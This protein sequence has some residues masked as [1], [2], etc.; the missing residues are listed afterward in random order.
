M[1]IDRARIH[2]RGGNGGNGI[3]AFRREKFVPRGGPSGGDGGRGGSV[4]IESTEGLNTLL[5]FRYNP[6]H[7]AG[8]GRHGEGSKRH[9][10]D[11]EDIVIKVPVGTLVTDELT[12]ELIHDFTQP[13][14]RV[15]VAAGGRGGR[16]NA[17]FATPTNRAPRYHE[18]GKEGEERWLVLELKLIADVG[19]V[20][21]PNAGKSTL[22]SRI[23]AARPKIADYPFTTLEPNLGVVDLGDFKTLVVADIPGLIEGAHA[24]AGLGDRFLRH[25]ERTKLLLHLV[26]V[27]G[28]AQDP[29]ADYQ[30]VTHELEAYSPEVAAKPKIAVATK[31]D[32]LDDPTRLEEFEQFCRSE[33]LEFH[34]ISAASGKGL[35]ELLRAVER[36]L[37]QLKRD[38]EQTNAVAAT[39]TQ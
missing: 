1:F 13:G 9:G 3:M 21:L 28:L 12:G 31:L 19:L 15:L 17:Q 2:V 22:I 8:R 7:V 30:T 32:A 6:E 16:G 34:S 24:G 35:K 4:F 39:I 33:G 26:D 36:K 14:E 23:S 29:I 25:V 20:G 11:A 37:D 38:E 10:A 18:E 5:H 27:S